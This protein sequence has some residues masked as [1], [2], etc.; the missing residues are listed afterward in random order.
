MEH[1]R[2]KDAKVRTD[3]YHLS[4]SRM[5]DLTSCFDV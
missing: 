4:Y 5:A 3:G 1:G 2:D